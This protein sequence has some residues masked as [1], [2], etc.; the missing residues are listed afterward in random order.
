MFPRAPRLWALLWLALALHL[1]VAHSFQQLDT[2]QEGS[3]SRIRPVPKFSPEPNDDG[4]QSGDGDFAGIAPSSTTDAPRRT[5]S[6]ASQRPSATDAA[7][8]SSSSAPS[9]TSFSP[10]ASAAATATIPDGQ[11]PLT[12]DITPGWGVSG[13]VMLLTGL[14]YTLVGIKNRWIHTFFSTAY[15]TALGVA[16]LIV[17]VMTVPVSNAV[18]GGY[19][20]AVVLSGC[21]V[22]AA[23]M[24]FKELTEGLG[25]ALGGFCVS[26]WLLCLVPG[27]LLRPVPAKAIFISA[28]TLVSFAFYFSRWTRDWALILAIAFSGAT[29]TV[30]GLDCFTRAGL[31]EFWAYIWNVN[32]NLF[33]L[34]ADTYPVTK[35]IRVEAAAIVIIFLVGIISQIK[36]W[37][38][39]REKREKRA[40]ERAEGQRNLELEEENVG[41]QIEEANARER[42]QW[43]RV[44]GHG[45]S[46]SGTDS[47]MSDLGDTGSEKKLRDSHTTSYR[48]RSSVEVM[49]MA[50]MSES[51]QS[52]SGH[53]PLMVAEDTRDGKVTVRVGVDDVP[54][55]PTDVGEELDEKVKAMVERQIASPSSKRLSQR[56]T[57][58]KRVSQAQTATEAPEVVPLPFSVPAH[59]ES[60]LEDDRSSIATFAA[61]DAEQSPVH[62][63]RRSLAKKLSRGSLS[64]LRSISQM[65]G[66]EDPA[67]DSGESLEELVVPKTHR[68]LDDN[69][70]LAAT[71]DGES[72]SGDDGRS[73]L[74]MDAR[75]SIEINAQ[76][77]DGEKK[78]TAETPEPRPLSPAAALGNKTPADSDD[79]LPAAS[80][81]AA[82]QPSAEAAED[83]AVAVPLD[84][85]KSTTSN[86]STPVSLTKDRLP[87]SLSR[88]AMSYRTNE[89]AKH[90][91]YADP[92]DLDELRVAAPARPVKADKERSVPVNVTEL[93]KTA[94]EGT[95]E[96]VII[97]SDSRA[98]NLSYV[99]SVSRRTS[100]RE[101]PSSIVA[102]ER[103]SPARNQGST[104][105]APGSTGLVRSTSSSTQ[106]RRSSSGLRPSVADRPMAA[107]AV[108]EPIPEERI[109]AR[110]TSNS[111]SLSGNEVSHRSTPSAV[112][113]VV[114]YN[115]PQTLIGQRDMFLRSKS[116]ANLVGGESSFAPASDAASVHSSS[117]YAA[118]PDDIPL[119]QRKHIMRQSSMMSLPQ[120]N[121]SQAHLPGT[122]FE[123]SD[124]LPFNSHQP[125]R[126]DLRSGTPVMAS[127]GRETPFAPASL[128][129]NREAE[130]A[131]AQRKE[132][133]RRDKEFADRAFDERMR[134]G[135]LLEAH[136]DA[137]RKMQKSARER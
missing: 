65:S 121:P 130:E 72:V 93:Q 100:K 31:K 68:Q 39:V 84:K 4:L 71:I 53:N 119:S 110:H 22:G 27:G 43:E 57:T 50:A 81:G 11:L 127:S 75:K 58:S 21:A 13:V 82:E 83:S 54:D 89:W 95:P 59:E 5:A 94:V 131:E 16:V 67:R 134:A 3:G 37:R 133:Q 101:R 113:G 120:P 35:G 77:C 14:T 56:T 137:M 63:Q 97:R 9:S 12:P 78:V 17:Y 24:F 128:L 123:S 124:N 74:S 32:A 36:L 18:Q 38:I 112:P 64:L 41:R 132:S 103:D 6:A 1:A 47:R 23:S 126:Q 106:I 7:S 85:A 33:P 125:R 62:P 99:P 28:F 19:V 76:L 117:M 29:I 34:G 79:R 105:A 86:S 49:D 2:R 20:V 52:R 45:L 108:A 44:Y 90:L 8:D 42:R 136:R 111:P 66:R 109:V 118:D 10:A 122:G 135:D 102:Q 46:G 88:V 25:C 91:S 30:L 15:I 60:R 116:Q 115:S 48:L 104:A 114:S 98:S 129:A 87:H 51:D 61:D 92:P 96:P 40:V 70:S 73:V 80:S 107:A 26:M 55:T 69:G